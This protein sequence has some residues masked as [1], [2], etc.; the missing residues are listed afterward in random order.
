MKDLIEYAREVI[1]HEAKSVAAMADRIGPSFA[2]AAAEVLRCRGRVI[3]AG[4]GKSGLVGKKI[5]ATFNS[6]G[7]SSFFLHPAEAMHGD[8]G[9]VRADDILLLISKSGRLG[10]MEIIVST[11][12]RLGIKI[13]LL[14]ATLESE[15]AERADIILDCSI[16]REAC[17]NNLVPTSSSTAALVMGDALALALLEARDFSAE[18]FA[19]LHPGGFIGRR[20]LKRVNEVYHT[21]EAMPLVG[22]DATMKEMILQ[23]TSK[24]LGC[25]VMVGDDGRPA[26]M[27]TDGDLRRLAEREEDIFRFRASEVMNPRP[28]L[29]RDTVLLDTALATMEQ[30]AITQLVTIDPEGRLSGLIHL[31]D[32]LKSKLV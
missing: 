1:R 25:V 19:Q 18:D 31:H 15:L 10:E 23:M 8:L 9:L 26:G 12:K 30:H 27:F 7:I 22:A 28:K 5:A 20:L 14:T 13:I 11:A 32:I 29:I 16:E 17:P 24:R 21:G 6:T 3:V 2:D 4:M